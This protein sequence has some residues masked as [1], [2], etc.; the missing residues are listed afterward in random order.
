MVFSTTKI[1]FFIRRFV[2]F[3]YF[4]AWHFVPFGVFSI[5]R[6]FPFGVSYYSTFCPIRRFFHSTFCTI[7]RF[8]HSTFCPI[9]RFVFRR[10][11][12]WH[13][14]L[15]TFVPSTFCRWTVYNIEKKSRITGG[16]QCLWST[17]W[18]KDDINTNLNIARLHWESN[19][20]MEK[21]NFLQPGL[22]KTVSLFDSRHANVQ[23]LISSRAL[24]LN[25]IGT[26]KYNPLRQSL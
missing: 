10:F 6:F 11:V 19:N 3:G 25:H 14:V 5:R 17:A 15:S 7:R 18:S 8:F 9:R 16:Y 24:P 26:T 13:F 23:Y 4:S 1:I 12:F 2:P 20:D 22:E 21:T